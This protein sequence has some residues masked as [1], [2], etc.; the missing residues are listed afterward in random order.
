MVN[1]DL[2]VGLNWKKSHSMYLNELTGH[3]HEDLG[4]VLIYL[5][6][7]TES[8]IRY[9]NSDSLHQRGTNGISKSSL[10]SLV[11]T[12]VSSFLNTVCVKKP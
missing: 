8:H 7:N 9:V 3:K 12:E 10:L 11:P 4:L 1:M 2:L 6:S 5:L